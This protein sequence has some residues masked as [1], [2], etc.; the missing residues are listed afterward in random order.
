LDF[1]K[2]RVF[3]PAGMTETGP[4]DPAETVP[5]RATGYTKTEKGEWR[6]NVYALPGRASSA[7]GVHSTARDLLR[8][9]S[10]ASG[11]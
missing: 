5:N 2:D 4:F 10:A 6:S 3:T 8:F 9:V 11:G 7:G 1:V